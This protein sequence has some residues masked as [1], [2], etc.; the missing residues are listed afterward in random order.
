MISSTINQNKIKNIRNMLILL[1][2]TGDRFWC[3]SLTELDNYIKMHDH[4]ILSILQVTS[5]FMVQMW[6]TF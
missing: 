2:H 6:T 3:S 4:D 1:I 5:S